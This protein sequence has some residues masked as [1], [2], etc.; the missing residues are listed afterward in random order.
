M[1]NMLDKF[2]HLIKKEIIIYFL[3]LFVLALIMHIDLLSDPSSRFHAMQAKENY[4]HPFFY[5]FVVYFIILILRKVIDFIMN[6]FKK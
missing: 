1:H 4:G 5:S 2:Q 6:L 3:T